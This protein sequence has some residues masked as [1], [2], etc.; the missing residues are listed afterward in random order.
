MACG[1]G[2]GFLAD[3]K[4]VA[5]NT[6]IVPPPTHALATETGA[7]VRAAQEAL[8]RE[9]ARAEAVKDPVALTLRAV[10][11]ALGGC[12]RLYVDGSLT[13]ARLA[14]DFRSKPPIEKDEMRLSILNGIGRRRRSR[15]HCPQLAARR[16][17]TRR[18]QPRDRRRYV[19]VASWCARRAAIGG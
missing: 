10:S 11:L 12:H 19:V 3:C 18:I 1:D 15:D 9:A 7:A 5:L 2:R 14:H 13:M 17:R 6:A 8:E 4:L 16:M